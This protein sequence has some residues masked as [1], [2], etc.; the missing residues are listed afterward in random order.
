MQKIPELAEGETVTVEYESAH[1][2]ELQTL[3]GNVLEAG[4]TW[5]GE[6]W[7]VEIKNGDGVYRVRTNKDGDFSELERLQYQW[8]NGERFRLTNTRRVTD[9]HGGVIE[10]AE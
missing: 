6:Q 2:D 10:I 1:S 7:E 3:T 4:E 8:Q 5:N 9:T